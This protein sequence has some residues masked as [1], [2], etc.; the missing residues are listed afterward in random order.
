MEYLYD[1]NTLLGYAGF[2]NRYRNEVGIILE[3]RKLI[4]NGL[5]DCLDLHKTV[6][7]YMSRALEV[8]KP[9]F[10]CGEMF[11]QS[12]NPLRSNSCPMKYSLLACK[13][14]VIA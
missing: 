8:L 6:Q 2:G 9:R 13:L 14:Q 1:S 7:K 10:H 3:P 4:P 5:F 12:M 11:E